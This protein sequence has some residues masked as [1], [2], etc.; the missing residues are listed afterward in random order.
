MLE[1]SLNIKDEKN[2]G[3]LKAV[4][5][6][7]TLTS[8]ELKNTEKDD[9]HEYYSDEDY[10][11]MNDE[12]ISKEDVDSQEP[13]YVDSEEVE[14]VIDT[15]TKKPNRTFQTFFNRINKSVSSFFKK[16]FN[17]K[18][19]FIFFILGNL[20]IISLAISFCFCSNRKRYSI[21]YDDK[22]DNDEIYD[23]NFTDSDTEILSKDLTDETYAKINFGSMIK[24]KIKKKDSTGSGFKY[25][26][27]NEGLNDT[28]K[29]KFLIVTS[30]EK[31]NNSFDSGISYLTE[32]HQQQYLVPNDKSSIN[33]KTNPFSFI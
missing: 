15:S 23:E 11:N 18:L 26:K 9:S 25:S 7:N 14:T 21:K 28:S 31:N 12:E 5:E 19:H 20:L 10:D 6:S 29:N 3:A 1:V 27:L 24:N 22:N 32:E 4:E 33:V 16:I 13:Y 8:D 2:D 17:N 30:N